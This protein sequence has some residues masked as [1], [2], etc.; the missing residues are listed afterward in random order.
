MTNCSVS[1]RLPQNKSG[2]T[3]QKIDPLAMGL[4]TIKYVINK[5]TEVSAA[6]YS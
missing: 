4:L 2:K 3:G 5:E 6:A 1:R